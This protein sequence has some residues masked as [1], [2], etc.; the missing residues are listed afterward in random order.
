MIKH[1]G[2]HYNLSCSIQ[3]NKLIFGIQPYFSPSRKKYTIFVIPP[4]LNQNFQFKSGLVLHC[5]V[6]VSFTSSI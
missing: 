2:G 6:F 1:T 4:I 3:P 5:V